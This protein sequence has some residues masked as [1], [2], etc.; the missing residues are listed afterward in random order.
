MALSIYNNIYNVIVGYNKLAK[1]SHEMDV[2][3][4]DE[5][6]NKA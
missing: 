2:K 1:L 5:S 6:W 4:D 3:E